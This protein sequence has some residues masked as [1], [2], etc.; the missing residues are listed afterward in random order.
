VSSDSYSAPVNAERRE[1]ARRMIE[2]V[3]GWTQRNLDGHFDSIALHSVADELEGIS[4]QI[5]AMSERSVDEYRD[6]D[7]HKYRVVVSSTSKY[8]TE[9]ECLDCDKW[10][11]A[12]A[13]DGGE[14]SEIGEGTWHIESVEKVE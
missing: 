13:R 14:F 9:I 6:P 11:E 1:K 4:R 5:R 10:T 8:E 7:V 12:R 2:N 3:H